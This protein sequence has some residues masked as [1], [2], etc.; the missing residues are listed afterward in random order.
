MHVFMVHPAHAALTNP[1]TMRLSYSHEI[2][3]LNPRLTT[4]V[5]LHNSVYYSLRKWIKATDKEYRSVGLVL[6]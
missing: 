5:S 4:I 3:T 6:T 1:S 2:G